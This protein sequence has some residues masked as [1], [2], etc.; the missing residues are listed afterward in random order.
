ME[1]QVLT[2]QIVLQNRF[3]GGYSFE[4]SVAVNAKA[5]ASSQEPPDVA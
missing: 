2:P 4:T 5:A 1:D 3:E